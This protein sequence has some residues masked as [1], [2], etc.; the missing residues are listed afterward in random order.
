MWE[1]CCHDSMLVALV[2]H[3]IPLFVLEGI[4]SDVHCVFRK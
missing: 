2:T 4:T 1:L 3:R